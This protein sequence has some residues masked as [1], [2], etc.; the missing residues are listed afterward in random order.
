[1]NIE[2]PILPTNSEPTIT[3]TDKQ[4]FVNINTREIIEFESWDAICNLGGIKNALLPHNYKDFYNERAV[5]ETLKSLTFNSLIAGCAGS[6]IIRFKDQYITIDQA[7]TL[8]EPFFKAQQLFN[9][10]IA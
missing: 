2:L 7:A 6:K 10:E 8:S 9:Q 1:M 3:M 5:E 4:R